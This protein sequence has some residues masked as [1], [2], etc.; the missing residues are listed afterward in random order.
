VEIHWLNG[1]MIDS[2]KYVRKVRAGDSEVVS[3]NFLCDVA[4]LEMGGDEGGAD[5]VAG[6]AGAGGDVLEAAPVPG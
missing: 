6:F 4:A 5:D 2:A 3:E 1:N